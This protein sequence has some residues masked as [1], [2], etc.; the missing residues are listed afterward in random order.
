MVRNWCRGRGG[1]VLAA[2]SLLWLV[3]CAAEPAD[4]PDADVPE[5]PPPA[6]ELGVAVFLTEYT[7]DMPSILDAGE[8]TLSVTNQGV[9]DHNLVVTRA[10]SNEVLWETDGNV[11]SGLTQTAT[12]DLEP[13]DYM[14][15]CTFAGHDTRGMFMQ[16]EVRARDDDPGR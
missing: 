7:I 6:E 16:L 15:V 1:S 11:G 2:L 13:G 10:G 8:T 5:L 12:I 3:A 14:V 9:E 4:S